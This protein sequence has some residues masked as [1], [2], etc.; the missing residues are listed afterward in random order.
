MFLMLFLSLLSLYI[1]NKYNIDERLKIYP[2]LIKIIKYYEKSS[3]VYISI[4]IGMALI[5]NLIIIF[6]M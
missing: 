5:F 6:N 1:I 4:E 3:L 2:R